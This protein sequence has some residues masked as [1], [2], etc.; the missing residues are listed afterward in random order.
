M[1]QHG[2]LLL[3]FARHTQWKV[4]LLL[5]LGAAAEG[6]VIA[7]G[8]DPQTVSLSEF[9]AHCLNWMGP[10]ALLLFC[11]LSALLL[12][13]TLGRGK[14][15]PGYTLLRLPVAPS[16]LILW[17]GVYNTLAYLLF[18]AVQAL[19]LVGACWHYARQGGNVGPQSF[20]LAVWESPFFHGFLP[21]HLPLG[22][23]QLPV[24]ALGLG[25]A[26]ASFTSGLHRGRWNWPF[27][28]LVVAVLI[29]FFSTSHLLLILVG[30]ILTFA[31]FF[32]PWWVQR[33]EEASLA[34]PPPAPGGEDQIGGA[35]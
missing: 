31:A 7:L 13:A 12:T 22:W 30:L 9:L 21:V 17:Q 23:V 5:A 32:D 24:V 2:S 15:R 11:L 27:L 3:L 28:A 16:R 8:P 4:L 19:M 34:A 33:A 35:P 29:L 20:Y 26:G 25:M 6:G 14:D 18:W 10:L 1:R